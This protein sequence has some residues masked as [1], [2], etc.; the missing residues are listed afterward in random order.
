MTEKQTAYAARRKAWTV[1]QLRDGT[2]GQPGFELV[3]GAPPID[4][5]QDVFGGDTGLI[6]DPQQAPLL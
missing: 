5:A 3:G 4:L 2:G 1:P 6:A